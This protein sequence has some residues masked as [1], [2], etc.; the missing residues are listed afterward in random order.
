MPKKLY[1]SEQDQIISGVAGGVAEYTEIDPVII[2]LVAI[3]VMIMTGILP[4]A[5]IYLLS[6]IVIPKRSHLD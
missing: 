6:A 1:R 3:F 4:M 2:R 5:F